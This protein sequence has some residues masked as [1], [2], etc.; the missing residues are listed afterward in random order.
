VTE[1][2]NPGELERTLERLPGRSVWVIGDLM[3]DEY[4]AGTT[5]RISPE[6]PVPVVRVNRSEYRLGGAANVARQL[7]AL[8]AHVCLGGVVGTDETGERFLALCR[9]ER[10]DTAAVLPVATRRTTRKL[11]VL[12]TNQQLLRL[13]WE[14]PSPIAAAIGEAILDRLEA[15][16][17]ADVVILSDYAKGVVTPQLVAR[18]RRSA[19]DH[20]RLYVDPKRRNFADYRGA[21]VITPN[22]A[23]LS[24]AVGRNL[25]PNDTAAIVSAAREVIDAAGAEAVVVTLGA[26]GMLVVPRRGDHT[27]IAAVE[28]AV[29]DVTGAGDTAIALLALAQAAGASLTHAAQ[30][31]SV[32]AGI[33]VSEVGAAAVAPTSI[34]QALHQ[35][36][37]SKIVSGA[38]LASR[39]ER[40]RDAGSRIVFTNGCFDLLHAGHLALLHE[41]ARLGDVLVVAVNSDESIER[42]KGKGRPL[43]P[44]AE[45]CA[46]LAALSC[47]DA[48]TVFD[49]DTPLE[50]LR[51]IRPDVLVK[52]QDYRV[53]DVVGREIVEAAGGRV[54][55]APLVP[56]RSTSALVEQIRRTSRPS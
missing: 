56:Q 34:L 35:Q 52:G 54:V 55:L 2:G 36:P 6:A 30:L 22:L 24:A 14:D 29:F 27:A 9:D 11:R 48:V 21:D 4:V 3:V 20:V 12:A 39:A 17:P 25:D 19:G 41:A 7:S 16:A 8:G 18:L 44:Q 15:G 47:V 42:L 40:W 23:E 37:Y 26:R 49:E 51:K 10:L 46:L 31:A 13:D 1:V 5:E 53:E 45:R 50:I 32:A 43:V 33:A 28:R 38:A